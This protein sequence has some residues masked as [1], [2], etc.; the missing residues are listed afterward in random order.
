M[1]EAASAGWS[2]VVIDVEGEYTRMDRPNRT[3]SQQPGL[4]RIGRPAKGVEDL[5]V[6][7]P[8][9]AGKR[10]G[11]IPFIV[12][13]AGY[14]L[15]LLGALLDAS[16]AQRRLLHAAID[17]YGPEYDLEQLAW[18]IDQTSS[19]GFYESTRQI[20]AE[21]LRQLAA[22]GLFDDKRNVKVPYPSAEEMIQPGRISV[23]DVSQLDDRTRNLTLGHVLQTAFRIVQRFERGDKFGSVERPPVMIVMEEVQTFFGAS[24]EAARVVMDFLQD[25][26]RRGRKRW[27]SMVMVSQQ[28]AALPMRLFELLNTRLIHQTKSETNLNALRR[29]CGDVDAFWWRRVPDL[30]PG[31]CLLSGPAV[32]TAAEVM[33]RPASS[34]RL[35]VE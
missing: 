22:K 21:R 20:L 15:E 24:D 16:D 5:K 11:T 34:E 9:P 23:I 3:K 1:E 35:L 26:A 31:S 28:P 13:I 6:F 14:D 2:V 33:I 10:R 25:V 7:L 8:A 30:V 12:P 19:E 18:A 17:R 27:L 4:T 29:S 32:Q